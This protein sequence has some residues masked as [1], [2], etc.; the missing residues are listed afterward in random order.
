MGTRQVRLYVQ[1]LPDWF[2]GTDSA[3]RLRLH[4]VRAARMTARQ[5]REPIPG[6]VVV[7]VVLNVDDD[8]FNPLDPV[9]AAV[10]AGDGHVEL[11]GGEGN[12]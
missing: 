7:P 8:V 2:E 11:V 9:Y 1:L 12:S 6:A 4:D 3:G 10:K 5:P